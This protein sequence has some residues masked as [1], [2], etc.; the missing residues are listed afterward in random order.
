MRASCY[1]LGDWRELQAP[2]VE[3]G[4]FRMKLHIRNNPRTP[5]KHS[6]SEFWSFC[7]HYCWESQDPG[8][9]GRLSFWSTSRIVLP[10]I[11]CALH[12]PIRA[13]LLHSAVPMAS[14]MTS[15]ERA[16]AF[17]G[18]FGS[19]F[20]VCLVGQPIA[21]PNRSCNRT[22][23]YTLLPYTSMY[24]TL[25]CSP[26][27]TFPIATLCQGCWE[28]QRVRGGGLVAPPPAGQSRSRTRLRIAASI[29][30]LFR[31]C[32]KGVFDTRAPLSR[33]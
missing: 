8:K 22:I 1:L 27:Q 4:M 26:P 19:L 9:H 30:F 10:S 32:F 31:A 28:P 18:C 7:L 13:D 6:R 16:L 29:A 24:H 21:K 33:G 14:N 15:S 11:C 5:W 23:P 2:S 17:G 25:P 20:C 12:G 3:M